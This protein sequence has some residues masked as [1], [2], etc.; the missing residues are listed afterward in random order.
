VISKI[1]IPEGQQPKILKQ[2]D[3]SPPLGWLLE[4]CNTA[5]RRQHWME[6]KRLYQLLHAAL[7]AYFSGDK[8]VFNDLPKKQ[9]EFAALMRDDYL[10][11]Y[12]VLHDGWDVISEELKHIDSY[13]ASSPGEML[14]KIIEWECVGVFCSAFPEIDPC[15]NGFRDFSPQKAYR[16]WS[17]DRKPGTKISKTEL[18][19]RL[20]E[21]W[22]HCYR[23]L[24]LAVCTQAART[25]PT[26]KRKLQEYR[27][28][29]AELQ[30]NLYKDAHPRK[31]AKG[32][33]WRNGIRLEGQKQGGTYT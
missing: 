18:K 13:V 29:S 21:N 6:V 5:D 4:D 1:A 11:L 10:S 19:K 12:G 15:G 8:S 9:K 7:K 14:V 28:V 2:V 20:R 25:D 3:E 33:A 30:E 24:C 17:E 22:S 16:R 23:G 27:R 31:Q 32:W 26:L